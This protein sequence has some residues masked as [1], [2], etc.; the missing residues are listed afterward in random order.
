MVGKPPTTNLEDSSLIA[1]MLLKK[2]K[3]REWQNTDDPSRV[4]FDILGKPEDVEKDM[5]AYYANE[6]VGIQDYVKCYKE[7]KS[8][9]YNFKKLN[10]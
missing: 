3:I 8:R 10:K 9:L 5:E 6:Q 1:F 2:H 7:V 4:S